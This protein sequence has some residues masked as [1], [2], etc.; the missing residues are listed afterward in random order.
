MGGG[1]GGFHEG[2]GITGRGGGLTTA[3]GGVDG[4]VYETG[5]VTI[6]FGNNQYSIEFKVNGNIH[7]ARVIIANF[8]FFISCL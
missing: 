1:G 3:E 7:N 2:V 4:H 8:L 6:F 5:G